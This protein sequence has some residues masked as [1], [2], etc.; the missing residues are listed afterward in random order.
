MTPCIL[1]NDY[2]RFETTC[3]L[4]N[5]RRNPLYIRYEK[6]EDAS[7]WDMKLYRWVNS[8]YRRFESITFTREFGNY[9]PIDRA[10]HPWERNLQKHRCENLWERNLQKHRCENLSVSSYDQY[11]QKVSAKRKEVTVR[12]GAHWL[13]SV[14]VHDVNSTPAILTRPRRYTHIIWYSWIRAS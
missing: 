1:V 5:S 11:L 12:H 7:P 8:C 9:W 10:S 13:L 2:R 14:V 6:S 3:C 4:P